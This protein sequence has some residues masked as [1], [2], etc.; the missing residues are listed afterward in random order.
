MTGE[1]HLGASAERS[2]VHGGDDRYRHILDQPQ[3]VVKAGLGK[4]GVKLLDVGTSDEGTPGAGKHDSLH[5]CIA[6]QL[7]ERLFEAGAHVLV[8][9]VDRRTIDAHERNSI[10]QRRADDLT[11]SMHPF[12]FD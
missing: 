10:V 12:W 8:H 4:A 7:A 5:L 6:A 1:R 11:H 9:G 2:A 3:Y